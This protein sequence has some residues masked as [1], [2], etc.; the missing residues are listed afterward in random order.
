MKKSNE[1]IEGSSQ[2]QLIIEIFKSINMISTENSKDML[3]QIKDKLEV[4]KQETENENYKSQVTD[5]RKSLAKVKRESYE[6]KKR[7]KNL[8]RDYL[9][10]NP[11]PNKEDL[12]VLGV[13]MG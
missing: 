12:Q 2:E 7:L 9:E 6:L 4:V 10:R 1:V 8:E 5:L 11:T 13:I 3:D